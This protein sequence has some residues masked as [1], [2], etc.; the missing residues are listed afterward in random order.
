MPYIEKKDRKKFTAALKT[1]PPILTAGELNYVITTLCNVY[2]H[3]SN[4]KFCY[5]TLN[6]IVGALESCKLEYYRRVV[7]PYE[8]VKIKENG[9]VF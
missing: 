4:H 6:D 8:G 1:L 9:D 5:Q 2:A 7:A 3:E